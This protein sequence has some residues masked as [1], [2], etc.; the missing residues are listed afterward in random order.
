MLG[1]VS[2]SRATLVV[3][4]LGDT[5]TGTGNTVANPYKTQGFQ[6]DIGG[7]IDSIT[8]QLTFN[9]AAVA[10]GSLASVYI[11]TANSSGQ[12]DESISSATRLGTITA[13][14]ASSHQYTLSITDNDLAGYTLIASN[15]YAL[16]VDISLTGTGNPTV[17][18]DYT[19]TGASYTGD[20][21]LERAHNGNGTTWGAAAAHDYLLSLDVTP[22][23]EPPPLALFGFG[24]LTLLALL[25]RK[26]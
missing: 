18:F 8:V 21:V 22:A 25:R 4:D 7:I 19:G 12:P 10:D 13:L 15:S 9:A 2:L 16:A 20:G 11:L 23:P 6:A 5:R 26:A 3:S 17:G 1:L 24:L 14:N